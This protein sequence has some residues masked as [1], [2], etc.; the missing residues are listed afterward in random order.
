MGA[1]VRAV[2][3]MEPRM[4]PSHLDTSY[5]L[6]ACTRAPRSLDEGISY[7]RMN[8][9]VVSFTLF[10]SE[11]TAVVK[12]CLRRAMARV[13]T[14]SCR[15]LAAIATSCVRLAAEDGCIKLM[16]GE[17]GMPSITE[18]FD[19][20]AGALGKRHKPTQSK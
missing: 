1:L 7:G 9:I 16:G 12:A 6:H 11:S 13:D 4:N 19:C 2:D 15:S 20:F 10:P 17:E 18:V 5:I 3:V 8:R 14:F